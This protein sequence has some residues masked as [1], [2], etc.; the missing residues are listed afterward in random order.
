MKKRAAFF[1]ILTLMIVS[2]SLAVY[3][4]GRVA[5][6]RQIDYNPNVE[7]EVRERQNDYDPIKGQYIFVDDYLGQLQKSMKKETA[8]SVLDVPVYRA[9]TLLE[10]NGDTFFLGRDMSYYDDK[11]IRFDYVSRILQAYPTTAVRQTKEKQAYLLYKADTGERLYLFLNT[12]RD[13]ETLSGFPILIGKM[14]SKE[15]F[16]HIEIGVSIKEVMAV[17]SVVSYYCDLWSD[18]DVKIAEFYEKSEGAP[19]TTIHYLKDGLLKITYHMAETR[20]ITVTGVYY[21]P[22]YIMKGFGGE[23][24]YHIADTDLPMD[25][26]IP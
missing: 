1:M 3:A 2:S 26:L 4:I 5:M 18:A 21:F 23:M 8:R 9:K 6:E 14:L 7:R 16:S 13:Y 25:Y 12:N 10:D 24:N 17:D 11:N 20:D 19:L 15:D 22:D